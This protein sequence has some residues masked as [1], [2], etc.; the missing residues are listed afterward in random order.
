MVLLRQLVLLISQ[1]VLLILELVRAFI[2]L[3]RGFE[4]ASR[5]L[6]FHHRRYFLNQII[7]LFSVIFLYSIHHS[8]SEAY[9]GTLSKI[10]DRAFC[11][12]SYDCSCLLFSQKSFIRDV[13]RCPKYASNN[14][15]WYK[16]WSKL[17]FIV[18]TIL[19]SLKEVMRVFIKVAFCYE[20]WIY[21][22]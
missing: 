7:Y 21:L 4:F 1:L 12:Y 15:C 17:N 18:L 5:V 3:T 19:L 6:F 8:K 16:F 9:L 22:A 2:L 13:R 10:Y 11:K 20:L 14:K